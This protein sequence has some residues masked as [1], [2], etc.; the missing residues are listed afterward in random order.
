MVRRQARIVGIGV[1]TAD[2]LVHELLSRPM[3]GRRAP[4]VSPVRT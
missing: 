4:A 1:E 2:L 3:R